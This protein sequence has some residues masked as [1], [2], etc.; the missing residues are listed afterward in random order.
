MIIWPWCLM[1]LAGLAPLI[2]PLLSDKK[3]E[4]PE[5]IAVFGFF[6]GA[7]IATAM[8]FRKAAGVCL[9]ALAADEV[10]SRLKLWSHKMAV[11]M[12]A[13]VSAGLIA[14]FAQMVFGNI[15]WREIEVNAIEPVLLL[16][17]I[18]C[19]TGFWTLLTRSTIGGILLT[20]VAQF[21]LYLLLV[22]FATAIDRMSPASP[23]ATRF[24]HEPGVHSALS[25]FVGG[26]ALS[27]AALMLWL[28]RKRF[29]RMPN[30]DENRATDCQPSTRS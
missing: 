26:F 20:G 14:C 22:L 6:G 10:A 15:V 1:T 7:A 11:L 19:S 12:T 28:G 29:A 2:K 18:V 13:I 3:S 30:R 16:V 8:S 5:A 9:P 27:Y 23:G 4:W 21:V 25:W 17:I 24:S